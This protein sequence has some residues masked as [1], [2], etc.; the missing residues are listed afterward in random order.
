M[1]AA[2][3]CSCTCRSPHCRSSTHIRYLHKLLLPLQLN[4]P[5]PQRSWLSLLLHQLAQVGTKVSL[6]ALMV[7]LMVHLMALLAHLTLLAQRVTRVLH[8]CS[9]SGYPVGWGRL[10]VTVS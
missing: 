1:A 2:V 4:H 8:K 6:P 3:A 5:G 10:G 9:C 7:H